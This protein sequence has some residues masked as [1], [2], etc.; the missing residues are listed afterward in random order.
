MSIRAP[1]ASLV[2]AVLALTLGL[3]PPSCPRLW[4]CKLHCH[5]SQ[6]ISPTKIVDSDAAAASEGVFGVGLFNRKVRCG[7]GG[8]GGRACVCVP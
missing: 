2:D 7:G 6:L 3:K 5:S 4:P 1:G 8:E